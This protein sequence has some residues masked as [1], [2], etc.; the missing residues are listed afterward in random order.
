MVD[1]SFK[2]FV[3]TRL[4]LL[5]L[6]T[7]LTG[8]QT[9]GYYKQAIQGQYQVLKHRQPMSELI[10][11][12]Q[13]PVSLKEKFQLIH[14]LREFAATELKLPV[15]GHYQ[16]YVDL[17]RRYIVWNVHA[18]P[19]FL[20]QPK[21]WWYPVVGSLKYRG[22][23]SEP[24]AK[25]YAE[26]LAGKG[27]DV[28]VD[29]V[30]AYSTL[31]WFKD[32]VLNTFINHSEPELAETIF[33]E[34][35]HQREFVRGDTDF[36]EAFATTVG[37]E[38]VRRWLLA[39][40]NSA[41]LEKY[42]L[43]LRRNEQFVQ[44]IQATRRELESLY[45]E[46]KSRAT[47]NGSM[48]T[49][50]KRQQK[51]II[52]GRLRSNYDQLKAQWSGFNDYDNWFTQAVNNAQL[53]TVATYYDMV[54]TFQRLLQQNNGDLEK[55]YREV[56]TLGKLPKTERHRRLFPAVSTQSEHH[57]SGFARTAT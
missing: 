18:A 32:L 34:L 25:R 54:P 30:E 24:D 51:E 53:N 27:F 39:S 22:Y 26:R 37:Q 1:E 19:E 47:T 35:A 40:G 23:F 48:S 56:R 15:N 14:K 7:G 45:G 29:G 43:A 21:T 44:L 17:H 3:M 41:A 49:A 31:G 38:G 4:P 28:F 36:N 55:F 6:A 8:C 5:L 50:G 13:T 11:D 46:E 42:Q 20:L 2:E 9:V 10:A 12:P 33:H 57:S 16:S 52:I